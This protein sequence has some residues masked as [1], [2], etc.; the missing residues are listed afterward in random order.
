MW[1]ESPGRPCSAA[2]LPDDVQGRLASAMGEL[3]PAAD[4]TIAIRCPACSHDWQVCL[5]RGG[6]LLRSELA[7]HA[8]QLLL[9]VHE[10]AERYGWSETDILRMSAHRRA[11]V[12][13][14]EY[15]NERLPA[16]VAAGATGTAPLLRPAATSRLAPDARAPA[17]AAGRARDGCRGE[18]ARG[19][20]AGGAGPGTPVSS[21][22]ARA[23]DEAPSQRPPVHAR[24][25]YSLRRTQVPDWTRCAYPP[26]APP[27]RAPAPEAPSAAVVPA[28]FTSPEP[29]EAIGAIAE[30]TRAPWPTV[31]E[32][33]RPRPRR[34]PRARGR[35]RACSGTC[36]EGAG[37]ERAYRGEHP[38]SEVGEAAPDAPGGERVARAPT[39]P[40]NRR[41]PRRRLS[42]PPLRRP[43]LP[44][45]RS[46]WWPRSAGDT[47][48]TTVSLRSRLWRR[49][50]RP[51]Y[52][53]RSRRSHAGARATAVRV[54]LGGSRGAVRG[55][56]GVSNGRL[57]VHAPPAAAPEP[58]PRA[59]RGPRLGCRTILR[60]PPRQAGLISNSLS[61]ATVTACIRKIL[62]N[63]FISTADEDELESPQVTTLPPDNPA[64]PRRASAAPT[65]SCFSA[66]NPHW[67]NTDLPTRSSD[68]KCHR[69]SP[70]LALDLHYL[71][72]F[73]GDETALEA[74]RL[75][76]IA[77]RTL[78]QQPVLSRNLVNRPSLPRPTGSQRS[79]PA[80]TCTRPRS[81]CG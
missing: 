67:R 66:R 22:V 78:H 35:G 17:A 45:C 4:I 76:G 6:V 62:E 42:P 34:A 37:R 27:P 18:R 32:P 23:G 73:Y 54:P 26:R 50:P 21:P 81:W 43:S 72:T 8:R 9:D 20:A 2:Q 39:G 3:N 75:L 49:A 33:E 68:A 36:R 77:S 46:W 65:S 71:V 55:A 38:Q 19:G 48:T 79:S 30:P 15:G 11:P 51:G 52:R 64:S 1:A 13:W 40:R 31:R 14:S 16:R 53:L 47:T 12:C 57:E 63:S 56:V 29:E 61:I 69:P 25:R 28:A 70:R 41:P 5:R 7:L 60:P 58:E 44:P 74:Q 10:L 24:E 80:P 59:R